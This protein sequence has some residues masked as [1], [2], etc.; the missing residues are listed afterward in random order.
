MTNLR[1]ELGTARTKVVWTLIESSG[2][3][4]D[5]WAFG[6]GDIVIIADFPD[7]VTAAG[8]MMKG[9]EVGE[10]HLR[11]AMLRLPT[12]LRKRPRW[13]SRLRCRALPDK[14]VGTVRRSP[15]GRQP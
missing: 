12:R 4:V 5:D 11:T 14:E 1:Q 3:K 2:G 13:Q 15:C 6:P 7:N 8:L 10:L 9:A